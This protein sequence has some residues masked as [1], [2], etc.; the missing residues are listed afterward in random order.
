MRGKRPLRTLFGACAL[1]VVSTSLSI[2]SPSDAPRDI[3]RLPSGEKEA[4][5]SSQPAE[6][7]KT[8]EAADAAPKA[9]SATNEQ[10]TKQVAQLAGN[11]AP[12]PTAAELMR[13][14]YDYMFYKDFA[15]ERACL[16]EA[17]AVEP[18][19]ED[20]TRALALLAATYLGEDP[21]KAD[22]LF[23]QALD[24]S[25]TPELVAFVHLIRDFS[26]AEQSQDWAR[27]EGVLSEAASTWKG[28]PT[29]AWAALRLGDHYRWDVEEWGKAIAT[30]QEVLDEYPV[31]LVAEQAL[32]SLAEC[33]NWSDSGRWEEAVDLYQAT[34]DMTNEPGFRIRALIGLGDYCEQ[35]HDWTA[36]W[37]TLSVVVDNYPDHPAAGLAAI[38]RAYAAQHLGYWEATVADAEFYLSSTNQQPAWRTYANYVLAED[39][40]RAGRYDEAESRFAFVAQL[41]EKPQAAEFRSKA[42]VGIAACREMRGDLRGALDAYVEAADY[43]SGQRQK[44]ICLYQAA[45]LAGR[46]GDDATAQQVA[47]RM[48]DELPGSHLTTRLLR[49]EVLPAPEI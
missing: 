1:L 18:G 31:G 12:A 23:A 10:S 9:T 7:A 2:A 40:F 6:K 20:G 21:A 17:V 3:A 48:A 41:A 47:D 42:R 26:M 46:L 15:N 38:I 32:V 29:G 30:F 25:S 5:V 4:V 19:T 44:A 13:Q 16:E 45:I 49:H 27:L 28:T 8:S 33:L 14:A 35:I 11:I 37:D 24:Q 36:C 34:L 22:E 43:A 39:A